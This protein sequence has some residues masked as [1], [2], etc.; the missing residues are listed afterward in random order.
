MQV[1]AVEQTNQIKNK[2]RKGPSGPFFLKTF[3]GGSGLW[4]LGVYKHLKPLAKFGLSQKNGVSSNHQP[5][6]VSTS[7]EKNTRQFFW[8]KNPFRISTV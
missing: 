8:A 6:S 4:A 5:T 7:L 1:P 3:R 2:K